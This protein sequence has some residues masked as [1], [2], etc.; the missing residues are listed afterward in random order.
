MDAKYLYLEEPCPN[1]TSLEQARLVNQL[2]ST[3]VTNRTISS[4][5]EKF[6]TRAKCSH[7]RKW[8]ITHV[9]N[10]V[11][12][13]ACAWLIL[14]LCCGSWLLIPLLFWV[15]CFQEWHHYCPTC[16]KKLK[17]YAPSASGELLGFLLILYFAAIV[18]QV[19]LVVKFVWPMIENTLVG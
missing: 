16:E 9:E 11:S 3:V 1:T 17:T 15:D 13:G 19:Y 4:R 2:S 12:G 7:C 14:C 6:R 18:L 10:T 8:V 5:F